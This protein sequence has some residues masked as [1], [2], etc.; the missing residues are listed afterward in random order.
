MDGLMRIDKYNAKAINGIENHEKRKSKKS[1]TNPN[2]DYSR[3]KNNYDLQN[4]YT[5]TYHKRAKEVMK[6]YGITKPR[7][8]AV[9]SCEYFFTASPEYFKDKNS[10]QIRQYFEKCFDWVANKYGKDKIIAA[11][12]HLDES[13]PHM[14]LNVVPI[15]EKGRLNAKGLLNNNF[16]EQQN[17]V[18]ADIFK[19][20][21]FER[22]TLVEESRRKHYD[23]YVFKCASL[24]I[25][26]DELEKKRNSNEFYKNQQMLSEMLE[27]L[28]SN[29]KLMKEY[30]KAI[31]EL[32]E[33]KM[34]N[35]DEIEP[36]I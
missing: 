17:Q 29:P 36:E 19:E 35:L 21:G 12:I 18:Y 32:R 5:G 10:V 23:P 27:V 31:Q 8:N 11:E 25:Q 2:I 33:L 20:L 7:S 30:K 3:S 16:R 1:K 26:C 6:K 34:A 4:V 24:K 28:Y 9:W 15:D 13:T 22:G 14:H